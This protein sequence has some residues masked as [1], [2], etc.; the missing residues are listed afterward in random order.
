M[1]TQAGQFDCDD[2][3]IYFQEAKRK[4]LDLRKFQSAMF[5]DRP[6]LWRKPLRKRRK[7]PPHNQVP[8]FLE[9]NPAFAPT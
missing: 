6:D 1:I 4:P 9:A 3:K 7:P 5:T 8:M 2:G